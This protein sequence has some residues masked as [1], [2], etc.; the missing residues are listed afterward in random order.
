MERPADI[1]PAG[2]RFAGDD[3]LF[4][5]DRAGLTV[6]PH[7]VLDRK[8]A[9]AG[10]ELP[11]RAAR[12]QERAHPVGGRR[13]LDFGGEV[14]ADR[15]RRVALLAALVG[16]E[17]HVFAAHVAPVAR[18]RDLAAME[19]AEAARIAVMAGLDPASN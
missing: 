5:R 17:Q 1:R 18:E 4:G 3:E 13:E 9:A 7:T 12:A 11:D 2:K 15:E 14:E 10:A 19:K 16:G 6:D 8:A